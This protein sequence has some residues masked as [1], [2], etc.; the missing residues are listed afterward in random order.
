MSNSFYV[1]GWHNDPWEVDTVLARLPTP[2]FGDT[3]AGAVADPLPDHV[4]LWNA[5]RNLG[6]GETLVKNQ[7]QVGSC[8]SFGT[9]S[10]IRCTMAAEIV[11]GD[12]EEFADIVEEVT[13]GGSRVE[14]G[15]GRISGDGSVGAWAAD[16]VRKWGVVARGQYGEHDLRQYDEARC[17]RYGREGVPRELEELARKHPVQDCSLV[18]TWDEAKTALA[19][20]YAIA[21]C[22]DQGFD[23][24]RNEDG[25]ARP[26]GSWAH[27][28]ALIGY[29]TIKGNEYGCINNSWGPNAHTGPLG[30]GDPPPSGFYAP[31]DVVDRMIRQG[32]S[33][34]FSRLVGFPAKPLAWFV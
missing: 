11:Q 27:C 22:S 26:S 4:F 18:K 32:D 10:A 5:V 25:I 24:R 3:P 19:Q 16:F 20:G 30:P 29:A 23:M 13:Y 21:I 2:L 33:W 1:P 7:G 14:V 15:G 12:P 34:A 6:H 8:V 28:M 31:A 9:N 17:R